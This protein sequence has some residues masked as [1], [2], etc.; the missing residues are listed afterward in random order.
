MNLNLVAAAA[1]A[2]RWL[3]AN[4]L[5]PF[6]D[7]LYHA[8]GLFPDPPNW[9]Y[10]L[11]ASPVGLDYTVWWMVA[12]NLAPLVVFRMVGDSKVIAPAAFLSFIAMGFPAFWAVVAA[13][14]NQY[15]FGSR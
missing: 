2:S 15:V 12:A 13:V 1:V 8:F 4:R 3:E 11:L 10:R 14:L 7:G 5:P 6:Q 9:V